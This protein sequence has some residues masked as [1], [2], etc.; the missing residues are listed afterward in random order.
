QHTEL[1][2]A[3]AKEKI[4]P[5]ALETRRIERQYAMELTVIGKFAEAEALY[6][7]NIATLTRLRGAQD[8]ETLKSRSDQI[9]LQVWEGKLNEAEKNVVAIEEPILRQFGPTSDE[10]LNIGTSHAEV[11]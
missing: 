1:A 6:V 10:G 2:Y 5:D 9:E 11:L 3:L 8:K 7:D 4:G